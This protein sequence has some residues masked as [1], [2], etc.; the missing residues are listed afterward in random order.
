MLEHRVTSRLRLLSLLVPQMRRWMR[1]LLRWCP[2]IAVE[3]LKVRIV[4]VSVRRRR[5][6]WDVWDWLIALRIAGRRTS[7]SVLRPLNVMW[8]A[9]EHH[10]R[11]RLLLSSLIEVNVL[12]WSVL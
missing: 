11:A 12:R 2:L 1:H 6:I 3:L 9:S 4:L 8:D 7:C 10:L 5:W